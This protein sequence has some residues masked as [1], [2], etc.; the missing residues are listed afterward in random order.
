VHVAGQVESRLV[1]A[2]VQVFAQPPGKK[3]A[4]IHLLSGGEKALTA[5]ALVFGIFKLNPAPFCLLDEVDKTA[6]MLGIIDRGRLIFQ[7]S[8]EELLGQSI[9]DLIL[10]TEVERIPELLTLPN[11]RQLTDTTVA[12]P[13]LSREN[14]AWLLGQMAALNVPIFEARRAQ[15]SL[16]EVF[17]DLTVQGSL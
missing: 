5:I 17:M 6:T 15:Q 3:N 2:G 10:E 16:E 11:A 7:G 12:V 4:S 1:D 8:R 13:N 14:V 9:P